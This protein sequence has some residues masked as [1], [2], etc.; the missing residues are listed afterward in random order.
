MPRQ[1]ATTSIRG[2]IRTGIGRISAINTRMAAFPVT[3]ALATV[4]FV[5]QWFRVRDT[6]FAQDDF[7]F[8]RV[9]QTK[10]FS[11][12]LLTKPIFEHFSPV[13]WTINK[14][15]AGPFGMRHSIA[16]TLGLAITWWGVAV[17]HRLV[18]RLSGSAWWAAILTALFG[19]S[20]VMTS[21][22]RWYTTSVHANLCAALTISCLLFF[23]RALSAQGRRRDTVLSVVFHI[24]AVLTHEKSLLMI[25][26]LVLLWFVIHPPASWTAA[27]DDLRRH[28]RLWAAH[29]VVAVLA[30]VNFYVNYYMALPAPTL[31][32]V[33]AYVARAFVNSFTPA[34]FG[35]RYPEVGGFLGYW[36]KV[37]VVAAYVI[38]IVVTV[39]RARGAWRA[40]AFLFITIGVN[41]AVVGQARM[42]RFG[43][44]LHDVLQYHQ[45]AAFLLVIGLALVVAAT[46]RPAA[47]RPARNGLRLRVG[48]GVILCMVYAL[49]SVPSNR[50]V[51]REFDM[52]KYAR[53]YLTT[54][55]RDARSLR[56][57]GNA[58]AVLDGIVPGE[59]V[60]D[61]FAPYNRIENVAPVMHI[62]LTF[63]EHREGDPTYY[64]DGHG[65][66]VEYTLTDTNTVDTTA[67]DV[68]T[69]EQLPTDDLC[70]TTGKLGGYLSL[71]TPWLDAPVDKHVAL[72]LRLDL[73][74]TGPISF[75]VFGGP[76]STALETAFGEPR[77]GTWQYDIRLTPTGPTDH[78]NIH[79]LGTGGE[80]TTC[81]QAITIGAITTG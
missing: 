33:V 68:I 24:G 23:V 72:V 58:P 52:G 3:F 41:F 22:L 48:V 76:D 38:A 26:Y 75:D 64:V 9:A 27:K 8:T 53:S 69:G 15:M 50:V 74:L 17:M 79:I 21:I 56:R 60:Y 39:R 66:L 28:W 45:E 77:A 40:W 30:I 81:L 55:E 65:H 67:I 11:Y 13:L 44:G 32:A 43:S 5:V 4:S 59:W 47:P 29:V 31:G 49:V 71:P 70:V 12:S 51:R 63:G 35:V 57:D 7:I 80:R 6:F 46:R 20:I 54:L 2:T 1:H 25:G 36:V 14:F 16:L 62:P 10:S 37:A 34:F 73:T 42:L 19:L 18:L 78:L 61:V